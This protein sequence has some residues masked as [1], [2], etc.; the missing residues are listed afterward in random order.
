MTPSCPQSPSSVTITPAPSITPLNP[1]HACLNHFY[2][3]FLTYKHNAFFPLFCN[4]SK[5]FKNLKEK[6]IANSA[7]A[8]FNS[9]M[10]QPTFN[11]LTHAADVTTPPRP[12]D[13]PY[14]RG[15]SHGKCRSFR[16]KLM[17]DKEVALR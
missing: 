7:K 5:H 11:F 10:V 14:G 17:G 1:F 13:L 2:L 16:D 4:T 12:L 6:F 15:D 3:N 8:N 9:S